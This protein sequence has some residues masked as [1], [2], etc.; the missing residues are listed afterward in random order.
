[1]ADPAAP[2]WDRPA[3]PLRLSVGVTGHRATH[4]VY[5]A[6]EAA[7]RRTLERA[8]AALEGPGGGPRPRLHSLLAPGADL[9]A[10]TYAQARGWEVVAP[11]PF[12]PDLN[13]AVNAEPATLAE[14]KAI[15]AA[16]RRT[17]VKATWP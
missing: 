17:V 11:L 9:L 14:T 10:A 6:N 15:E 12:G 16:T 8:L 2:E 5:A 4:A 13:A 3:P 7:I 1:M